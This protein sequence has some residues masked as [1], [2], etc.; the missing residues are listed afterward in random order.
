MSP[1]SDVRAENGRPS[2]PSD[3]VAVRNSKQ[4]S[5]SL[6]DV[7]GA[8]HHPLLAEQG[9]PERPAPAFAAVIGEIKARGAPLV[10]LHVDRQ[11]EIRM[12]EIDRFAERRGR[13]SATP[14]GMAA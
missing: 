1:P 11:R 5:A 2:V 12:S 14:G 9:K 13:S 3:L 10:I 8:A 4:V 6:D 7:I